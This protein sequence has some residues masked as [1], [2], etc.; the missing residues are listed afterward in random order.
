MGAAVPFLRLCAFITCSGRSLPF[1]I[2]L[3]LKIRKEIH[4]SVFHFVPSQ[5][6]FIFRCRQLILLLE[7]S[8]ENYT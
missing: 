6:V 3:H 1:A 4:F 7:T 8:I 5:I 2:N